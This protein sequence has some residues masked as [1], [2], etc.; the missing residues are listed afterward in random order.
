MSRIP[1]PL[2][3]AF[4]APMVLGRPR[5]DMGVYLR[6]MDALE[7]SRIAIAMLPPGRQ[8][9]AEAIRVWVAHGWGGR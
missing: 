3:S 9:R 6:R 5:L 8:E 4:Y 7:K 2:K 1:K